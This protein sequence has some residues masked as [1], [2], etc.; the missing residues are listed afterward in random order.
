MRAHL[1]IDPL[2]VIDDDRRSVGLEWKVRTAAPLITEAAS[3][4]KTRVWIEDFHGT[5][6]QLDG[7]LPLSTM[8]LTVSLDGPTYRPNSGGSDAG[9]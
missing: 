1:G 5:F 9:L 3:K 4:R 8:L 6:P 2:P 7:P